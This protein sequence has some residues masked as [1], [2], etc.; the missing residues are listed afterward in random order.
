M[1][2][3]K[4]FLNS[5]IIVLWCSMPRNLRINIQNNN[6]ACCLLCLTLKEGC[7]LRVSED[8]VLRRIFGP[9]REEMAGSWRGLHDVELYRMRWAGHVARV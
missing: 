6:F 7:R 3:E 4:T 9:K 1:F 8:R 2:V 5:L